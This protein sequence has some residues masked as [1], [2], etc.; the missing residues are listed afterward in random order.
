[1]YTFRFRRLQGWLAGV[2]DRIANQTP[3]GAP[4]LVTGL[5]APLHYVAR[6][7]ARTGIPSRPERGARVDQVAEWAASGQITWGEAELLM[8]LEETTAWEAP[9]RRC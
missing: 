1:M 3:E 9:P 7:T 2:R 6:P 8:A 4:L 5:T